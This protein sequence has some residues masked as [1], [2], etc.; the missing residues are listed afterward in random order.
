MRTALR[1]WVERLAERR[2][3]L[4]AVVA[5]ARRLTRIL[6][7]PCGAMRASTSR[8]ASARRHRDRGTRPNARAAASMSY[9]SGAVTFGQE[10]GAAHAHA[11]AQEQSAFTV[12]GCARNTLA[13]DKP[14]R[15]ATTSAALQS[16]IQRIHDRT[17]AGTAS[18]RIDA[19]TPGAFAQGFAMMSIRVTVRRVPRLTVAAS[20]APARPSRRTDTEPD[21]YLA[22]V[23]ASP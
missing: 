15:P 13:Y 19:L 5:L 7:T 14:R 23:A 11:R 4:R 18:V 10:W 16:S 3:K 2:G 6:S 20:G 21:C 12:L 22:S 8:P 17:C 1:R 9:C